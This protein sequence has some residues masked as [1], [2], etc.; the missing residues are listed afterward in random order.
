M[1]LSYHAEAEA[2]LIDA[3]EFYERRSSGLGRRFLR[4]FD[5]AMT[6]ISET[7]ER[8]R[9]VKAD[10]RRFVMRRFPYGIDYRVLP[11]ELRVLAVKHH[12]RHPNYWH[13]RLSE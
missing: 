5:A 13:S 11:D 2:E 10:V 3:I 8:W 1:R 9:V 6:E 7:P 4:A 12:S